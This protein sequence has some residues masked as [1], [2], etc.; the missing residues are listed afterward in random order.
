MLKFTGG[1]CVR[2]LL[3]LSYLNQSKKWTSTTGLLET[4]NGLKKEELESIAK[5]GA[6]ESCAGMA[7]KITPEWSALLDSMQSFGHKRLI[8]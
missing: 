5:S 8:Y 2:E 4:V 1:K 3:A 7:Y 6:I